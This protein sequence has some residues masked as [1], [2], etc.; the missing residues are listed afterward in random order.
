MQIICE[1]HL[2]RRIG[3]NTTDIPGMDLPAKRKL[4]L[5]SLPLI[6]RSVTV[7]PT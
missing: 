7:V 3:A 6:S 4:V 5:A 1:G 2:E